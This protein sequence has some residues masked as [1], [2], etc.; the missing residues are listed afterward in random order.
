MNSGA[1][2]IF[3]MGKQGVFPQRAG[4]AHSAHGTPHVAIL[5]MSAL[6]FCIPSYMMY[7]GLQ[8]TDAFNDAGTFGAFGFVGGYM[9]VTIAAPMYLKKI[10]EIKSMDL[11]I[12]AIGVLLLLVPAVGSVW[13]VPA[14][15]VNLFPYIFGTYVLIGLAYIT[16]RQLGQ[17]LHLVEPIDEGVVVA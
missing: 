4:T 1:R 15:P 5:V 11:A 3:Q 2:L 16:A 17:R 12:S 7:L 9:F 10:G 13:P 8:V 6:Q 14:A